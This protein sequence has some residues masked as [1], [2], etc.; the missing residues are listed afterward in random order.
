MIRR[1]EMNLPG[2]TAQ[3]SLYKTTARYRMTAG[4]VANGAILPQAC[5]LDCLG[6][7]LPGCEG[8]LGREHAQCVLG[9]SRECGCTQPQQVCGPCQ[10]DP[11]TGW[12]HR[13]C[14]PDGTNCSRRP[15]TP[16]GEG[17]T[18]QDN[19]TCLPWPLDDICWGSCERTCCHWSGC[20]Q[21]LCGVSEC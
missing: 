5:D 18:V 19:R 11:L 7:C 4:F 16:P 12:S 10:C 20:D 2:F 14:S 13:C 21:L 6:E 15:C 17:C 3:S 1:L 8:L 9:C